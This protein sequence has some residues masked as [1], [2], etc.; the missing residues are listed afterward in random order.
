MGAYLE[1]KNLKVGIDTIEGRNRVLDIDHFRLEKGESFG[2]VGESGSGKTILAQSILR[3]LPSPPAIIESGEIFFQGE[4]LLK[5]KE[6]RM[7]S[8]IRGE[9]IS[10]IFQDPMSS[11]NPVFRVGD[12]IRN[13]IKK[14]NKHLS[15]KELD[16]EVLEK[17][18]MVKLPDVEN[19]QN[20]YP[21]ELSGGQRQR[22]IIAIALSCGAELLIADE[23]TRNL[24]VTIQAGVLKLLFGLKRE[25]GITTLFIANNINLVFIV[26][27]KVAVLYKGKIIEMGPSREI[28]NNPRHPYTFE[29]LGRSQIRE[30]EK[31]VPLGGEYLR[32]FREERN[33]LCPFIDQCGFAKDECFLRQ[34]PVVEVSKNHW[35]SCFR[36]INGR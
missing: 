10:M 17:L 8:K 35:V 6:K 5:T 13:V 28:K 20:K 24:D 11:L 32:D 33:S 12:Q 15:R 23:P 18:R 3:I 7:Q 27:N 19:T 9:K 1:I 25:L 16:K 29:L 22:V 30:E 31:T 4:D 34:P 21:N 2:I 36:E 26:S 14:H